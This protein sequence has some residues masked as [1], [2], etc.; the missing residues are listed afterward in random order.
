MF[1]TKNL[2]TLVG[3]QLLI[4][5]GFLLVAVLAVIIF[6]TQITKITGDA[7]KNR[8]TAALL[9]ERAALL[10]NLKHETDIIG[11]NN[12]IIKHAFI[13]T[14]NILDFVGVIENLAF[15]NGLTQAYNFSAP[16]ISPTGTSFTPA[17]ITYQDTISGA[18]VTALIK[19]LK[20]FE[21]LPYFTKIDSL[22]FSAGGGDWRNSGTA[23]FGATVSAQT[24]E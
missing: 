12:T 20:E 19:Y 9:S 1:T 8:H 14:N 3:K 13:P 4:A 23:S 18:N 15:R 16:T 10:S 5:G 7:I 24:V 21:K 6:S 22:N 2:F 11:S 17:I